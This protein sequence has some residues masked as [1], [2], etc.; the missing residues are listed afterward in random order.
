MKNISGKNKTEFELMDQIG[1]MYRK[2]YISFGPQ[3]WEFGK[4]NLELCLSAI[5]WQNTS[6]E[7]AE[8][9]LKRIQENNLLD[10]TKISNCKAEDFAL[11]IKDAKQ[12]KSKAKRII[13]FAKMIKEKYKGELERLLAEPIQKF[14]RILLKIEGIGKATAD[15]IILFT[16]S[17]PIFIVNTYTKRFLARHNLIG[18]KANYEKIQQLFLNNLPADAKLYKEYYA[19]IVKVTE[20]YCKRK[21]SN[22]RVCPLLPFKED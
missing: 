7:N 6:W 21:K 20:E 19:L 12:A 11:I 22:C 4:S 13:N 17:Y 16:L 9:A 1:D 8:K 18:S 15:T 14:R 10:L 3:R 5:L 2:L